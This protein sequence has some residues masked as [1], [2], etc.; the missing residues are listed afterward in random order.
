MIID[1]DVVNHL[2]NMTHFSQHV[3]DRHKM[4][5]HKVDHTTEYLAKRRERPTICSGNRAVS[6]A[7]Y[8]SVANTRKPTQYKALTLA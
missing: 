3:D 8:S 1:I 5:R 2:V 6:L 7:T 4:L